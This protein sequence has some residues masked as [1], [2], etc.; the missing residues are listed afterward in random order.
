MTKRQKPKQPIDIALDLLRDLARGFTRHHD[1]LRVNGGELGGKLVLSYQGH[2]EDHPKL[3]GTRGAHVFAMTTIFSQL[4]K[5]WNRTV[6]LTLLE[7]REKVAAAH[8]PYVP[9]ANWN[10]KPLLDLM[11][12]VLENTLDVY[13]L[14]SIGEG[15]TA[16]NVTAEV[17]PDFAQSV[18]NIFHAIGKNQ[19]RFVTVEFSR[20]PAKV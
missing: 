5:K 9:D 18:H 7:P 2:G 11:R 20:E 10:D 8:I 19:G 4:G 14:E 1:E 6:R 16:I 13:T 17:T 3:V 15:F 12:R